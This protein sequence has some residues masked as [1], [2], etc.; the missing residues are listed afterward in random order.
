MI[1]KLAPVKKGPKGISDF[2]VFFLKI[3]KTKEISA[4]NKKD[5]NTEANNWR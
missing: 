2:R 1:I 4:P 3:I 5:R